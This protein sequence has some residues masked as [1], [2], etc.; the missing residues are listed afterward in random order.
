MKFLGFP[1]FF[2]VNMK[3]TE[4]SSDYKGEG[5]IKTQMTETLIEVNWALFD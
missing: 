3:N 1:S 4:I 2:L 5:G